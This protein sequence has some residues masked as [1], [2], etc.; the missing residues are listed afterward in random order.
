MSN[1]VDV[2]PETLEGWLR[3]GTAVVVDVREDVEFA[4]EHIEGAEHVPLARLEPDELKQRHGTTRVVFQCRSGGRSA[5]AAAR[6]GG[7]SY[8]LAG[9]IQAWTDS[10]RGTIKAAGGPPID[11]MR[12]VQI[13]AGSLVVLGV[14][15]SLLVSPWLLILSAFV[16]CGL[17]FAGA[18]GWCG[19]AKLL[20]VMP[21]NQIR[22]ARP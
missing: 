6:F 11:I 2:S 17:V 3:E 14:V 9:G 7:P 5:K 4:S 20:G 10:G 21:W 1:V 16:G 22:P 15:L 8:Q 12:Q 19:M 18:S 13:T